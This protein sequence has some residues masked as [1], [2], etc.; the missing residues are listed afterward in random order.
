MIPDRL[1]LKVFNPE[2][3]A[4]KTL[5]I[6]ENEKTGASI[7]V[8]II[9]TCRPTKSCASYCYGLAGP[10]SFGPALQR[11]Y[12]NLK[13]FEILE[14]ASPSDVDEEADRVYHAI[15]PRYTYLR[16][17]GVGDLTP[18]SVRFINAMAL[19]HPNLTLWVPTRKLELAEQIRPMKNVFLMMSMDRTTSPVVAEQFRAFVSTRKPYAFGAYVQQEEDD[20]VP[21]WIK[22]IFAIHVRGYRAKWSGTNTDPR[23]CPATVY[24][25]VSHKNA[26]EECRACFTAPII[27]PTSKSP[28]KLKPFSLW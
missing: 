16:F 14:T 19:L 26:C 18:G 20:K 3:I 13:R 4:P 28:K 24:E 12:Q 17:F 27:V 23:T 25:G 22:T 6:S 15:H 11:Q 9:G 7:N 8:P 21:G 2:S 5:W 1:R 10:I